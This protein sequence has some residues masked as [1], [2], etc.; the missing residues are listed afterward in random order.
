[1]AHDAE[2]IREIVRDM[3]RAQTDFYGV[4]Y[5]ELSALKSSSVRVSE[6]LERLSSRIEEHIAEDQKVAAVVRVLEGIE[7]RRAERARVAAWVAKVV[8]WTVGIVSTLL[9]VATAIARWSGP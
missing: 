9:G 2:E 5:A 4:V 3:S 8:A 7:D 1:M 6:R